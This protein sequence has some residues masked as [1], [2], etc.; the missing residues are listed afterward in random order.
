[1]SNNGKVKKYHNILKM[2]FFLREKQNWYFFLLRDVHMEIVH[3]KIVF[4]IDI[5]H[6]AN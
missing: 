6:I 4:S 3:K 1:M 5:L 2:L